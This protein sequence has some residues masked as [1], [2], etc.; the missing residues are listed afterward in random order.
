M[1]LIG[2]VGYL[3]GAHYILSQR[4]DERAALQAIYEHHC[5]HDV[6]S[7]IVHRLVERGL[8][9]AETTEGCT[10]LYLTLDGARARAGLRTVGG[11]ASAR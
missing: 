2:A 9:R 11:P 6:S 1:M 3:L 8:V 7:V 4:R 5:A 10:T